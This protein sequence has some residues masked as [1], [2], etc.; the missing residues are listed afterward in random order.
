MDGAMGGKNSNNG[1]NGGSCVD[2]GAAGDVLGGLGEGL[3]GGNPNDTSLTRVEE[4]PSRSFYWERI[5][6]TLSHR[7]LWLGVIPTPQVEE[8][9][10]GELLEIKRWEPLYVGRGQ[11]REMA[12]L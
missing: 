12:F 8:T 2:G 7:A 6:R 10:G 1:S 5:G 3:P 4:T 9:E 11:A